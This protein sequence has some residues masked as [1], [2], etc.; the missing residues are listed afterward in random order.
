LV[1][2]KSTIS[3]TNQSKSRP[4]PL[5]L[6]QSQP[7]LIHPA[8]R[9]D[10]EASRASLLKTMFT[11]LIP[12]SPTKDKLD[13]NVNGKKKSSMESDNRSSFHSTSTSSRNNA[14]PGKGS[15]VR[16][17]SSSNEAPSPVTH[18]PTKTKRIS[19][20]QDLF[21]ASE[22]NENGSS[23]Q[24]P[25]TTTPSK[26]AKLLGLSDHTY[27][28][29]KATRILGTG[30]TGDED[31][32]HNNRVARRLSSR[33]FLTGQGSPSKRMVRIL[34]G[35]AAKFKD[36]RR[37]LTMT[38][39]LEPNHNAGTNAPAYG[40]NSKIPMPNLQIAKPKHAPQEGVTPQRT[41]QERSSSLKYMDNSV[42]PTPP[43]KDTI[44]KNMVPSRQNSTKPHVKSVF[45]NNEEMME[46]N[47]SE[48]PIIKGYEST[49]RANLITKPSI[50]S[51]S[52]LIEM[53]TTKLIRQS[54]PK[55]EN[56]SSQVRSSVSQQ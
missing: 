28:P 1:E 44:Y 26:A 47:N 56:L 52:G 40:H 4:P 54:M 21:G 10:Q 42:P 5:K 16:S 37:S 7:I 35:A 34:E 20:M 49:L 33:E 25:T 12:R 14:S 23:D 39:E 51:F 15:S 30:L 43:E 19:S 38:D 24:N 36:N 17:I 53:D 46:S 29:S 41:I 45:Q 6:E 13:P 55:N 9:A 2:E 11:S 50:N 48:T 8:H 32:L 3:V 22:S 31:F 27:S 18:T